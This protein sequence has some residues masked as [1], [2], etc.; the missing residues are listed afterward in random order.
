MP[1]KSKEPE[2]TGKSD[3]LDANRIV[4]T[5]YLKQYLCTSINKLLIQYETTD[6]KNLSQ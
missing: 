4:I 1:N 6:T 5:C 3:D 2:E